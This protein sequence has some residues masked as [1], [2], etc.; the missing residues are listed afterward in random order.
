MTDNGPGLDGATAAQ[1]TQR[2]AQGALGQ[3]LGEGAGLGLAI[4]RRYAE[5]L[6]AQLGLEP[7]P[8]AQGL[9]ARLRF[10]HTP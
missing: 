3:K 5:L 9:C 8:H 10:R 1:V 4:V 6:D 7:V 2:W